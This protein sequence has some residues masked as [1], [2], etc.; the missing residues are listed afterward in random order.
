VTA[1]ANQTTD[2]ASLCTALA[3]DPRFGGEANFAGALAADGSI[4]CGLEFRAD[5]ASLKDLGLT[6]DQLCPPEASIIVKFTQV[7]SGELIFDEMQTGETDNG[8]CL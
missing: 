8:S 6:V 3:E 5:A 2:S 1:G 7:E 4:E